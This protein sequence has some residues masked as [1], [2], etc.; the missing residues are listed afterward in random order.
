MKTNTCHSTPKYSASSIT[1]VISS[2]PPMS[3]TSHSPMS[4]TTHPP[5]S[6]TTDPPMFCT[7]H[8]LMFCTSHPP[9]S[10]TALLWPAIGNL[11]S[12]PAPPTLLCP[13]PPS[14]CAL[15]Q[16]SYVLNQPPQHTSMLKCTH[17]LYRIPSLHWS[18]SCPLNGGNNEHGLKTL[19]ANNFLTI[20]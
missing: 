3:F 20:K 9:M 17:C 16:S 15:H 6:G 2:H 1:P 13:A 5:M 12:C 10:R 11:L 18:P 14:P 19:Y 7:T 4:F 8:S